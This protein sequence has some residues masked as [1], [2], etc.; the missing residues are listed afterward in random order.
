MTCWVSLD[1]SIL[2]LRSEIFAR[3][4]AHDGTLKRC[5]P[6]V[7]NVHAHLSCA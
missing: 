7:L 4:L 1:L 3:C 6:L 2:S 5:I